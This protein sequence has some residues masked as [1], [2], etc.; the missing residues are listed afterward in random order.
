MAELNHLTEEQLVWYY[1]GEDTSAD[2]ELHLES[3]PSCA[4][5]LQQIKSEMAAIDTF[6]PP[7]PSPGFEERMWRGLERRDASLTAR[8]FWWRRGFT[9]RRLAW[10]SSA[11]AV[12]LA[13]F[14][15][16]RFS[17][18]DAGTLVRTEAA[19]REQLLVAALSDHLE[20]SERLLVE[21]DNL[22]LGDE[23]QQAEN[24]LAANR[25]YRQTAARQGQTTLAATLEDLERV[26][27]DV[28]HSP[29]RPS[30]AQQQA[31]QS[32]MDDQELLFKV[33]ALG[34]QLRN[35]R[36]RNKQQSTKG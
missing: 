16:G 31:W 13:A 35:N 27:L 1:Y 7:V 6:V 30:P 29:G 3:C 34:Q 28:A 15:A 19:V 8:P 26:L 17:R 21:I 18:P 24:L 4:R 2:V 23:H 14:L 33:Q 36:D 25:L 12:L 22:A 20:Q 11:V 9:V 32:R 10:A 5:Q